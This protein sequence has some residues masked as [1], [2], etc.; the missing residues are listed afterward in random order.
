MYRWNWTLSFSLKPPRSDFWKMDLFWSSLPLKGNKV[1]NKLRGCV[2]ILVYPGH[3]D[4]QR[5]SSS[6][7]WN[8]YTFMKIHGSCL[9]D[10]GHAVATY[11]PFLLISA[12]DSAC[13]EMALCRKAV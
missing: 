5:V 9:L 7:T 1:Q 11:P 12:S 3:S 13:R 2:Q 4:G 10:N 6:L 8:L